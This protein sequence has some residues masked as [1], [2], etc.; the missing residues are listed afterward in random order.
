MEGSLVLSLCSLALVFT[1]A[2]DASRIVFPVSVTLQEG[3]TCT[4]Y[5]GA[6]GRCADIRDCDY[7][8]VNFRR[9]PPVRCGFK[10]IYP[11]VCCPSASGEGPQPITDIAPPNVTFGCT[12]RRNNYDPIIGHKLKKIP[13]FPLLPMDTIGFD[14]AKPHAWPWMALVGK[15]ESN[16]NK[17]FCGGVLINEQWVLTA[18]HCLLKSPDVVRLGE[19]DYQHRNDGPPHEDFDVAEKVTYPGYAHPQEYHDLALLRLSSR[20]KIKNSI[21]PV[22]LPWGVENE[23]D[24]TGQTATVT[25]YG[26]TEYGGKPT[27]FLQ[28]VKVTVFTSDKCDTSYSI[29]PKYKTSWPQG[30]G[31][32]TLCAGDVEGG[33]DACQGDSGGPLVTKDVGGSFVLAGIVVQGNGCGNKDFPGLYANM[34]YPPYLVWIKNVAF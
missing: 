11:V 5:S 31:E 25:G 13:G 33:K 26:D 7:T 27:T 29:L 32:E 20:V 21:T 16:N 22:C 2:T 10:G 1:A 15:R 19:H 28:Q 12:K 3:D 4:L 30:I 14:E 6:P 34:R 17:W 24:I 23:V 9:N 8:D 18:F